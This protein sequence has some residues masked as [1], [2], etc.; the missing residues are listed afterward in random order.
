MADLPAAARAYVEFIETTT[1]VRADAVSV[2]PDR[3][4]TIMT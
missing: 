4:Q 3:A 2:G 1:Q